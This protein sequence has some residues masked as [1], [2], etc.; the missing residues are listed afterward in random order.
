M[1]WYT[2][3]QQLAACDICPADLTHSQELISIMTTIS[4]P[5]H[6]FV[7]K[8]KAPGSLCCC[9]AFDW[10]ELQSCYFESLELGLKIVSVV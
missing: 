8:V 10:A 6:Q 4:F 1:N 3:G 2:S 7:F 5:L 9:K